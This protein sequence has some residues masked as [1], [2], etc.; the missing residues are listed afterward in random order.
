METCQ[1]RAWTCC[2]R[3]CSCVQRGLRVLQACMH[4]VLAPKG[5]EMLNN[6]SQARECRRCSTTFV[7]YRGRAFL[8]RFIMLSCKGCACSWVLGIRACRG[9]PATGARNASNI[10][11]RSEAERCLQLHFPPCEE[12]NNEGRRCASKCTVEDV[13]KISESDFAEK[14]FSMRSSGLDYSVCA[15]CMTSNKDWIFAAAIK[16]AEHVGFDGGHAVRAGST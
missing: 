11:G 14:G 16:P 2:N 3:C 7:F 1:H 8:I 12:S 13:V 4:S 6:I 9:A 10:Q 5:A 15:G